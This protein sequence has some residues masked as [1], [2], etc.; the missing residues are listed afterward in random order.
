MGAI[1][2]ETVQWA[3]LRDIDDV[4]PLNDTDGAVLEEIR[5]VLLRHGKSERFGVCLLHKHFDLSDEEVAVEYTDNENRI[6]QIIVKNK[7]DVEENSVQTIWRFQSEGPTMG[8]ICIARCGK[9]GMTHSTV[10]Q[11]QSV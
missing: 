2:L 7:N 6:S 3:S 9:S 8:T 5:Q 11:K 4:A 10:H 1:T